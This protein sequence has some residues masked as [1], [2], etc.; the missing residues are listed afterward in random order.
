MIKLDINGGLLNINNIKEIK[1][2]KST[3]YKRCSFVIYKYV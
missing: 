2:Q 1:I 3:A